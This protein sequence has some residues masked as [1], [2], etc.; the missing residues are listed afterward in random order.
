M[1]VVP[2]PIRELRFSGVFPINPATPVSGGVYLSRYIHNIPSDRHCVRPGG[3]GRY[4]CIH[5]PLT[6]MNSISSFCRSD[7]RTRTRI[8]RLEGIDAS[9]Y[10]SKSRCLLGGLKL[11]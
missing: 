1:A 2:R 6:N 11:T 7:A 9:R 8:A 4:T 10:T 3:G 5:L